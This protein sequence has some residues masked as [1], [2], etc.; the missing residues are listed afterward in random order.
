[1]CASAPAESSRSTAALPSSLP[2][3]STGASV[4]SQIALQSSS[5]P[6]SLGEAAKMTACGVAVE[7]LQR[8]FHAADDGGQRLLSLQCVRD[9]GSRSV[10]GVYHQ[11]SD[12]RLPLPLGYAD[13]TVRECLDR[14]CLPLPTVME[15]STTL[16][17]CSHI[18]AS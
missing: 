12:H 8:F 15:S 13:E 5:S 10:L 17:Y 3:T 11:Y 6:S 4:R 18:E 9:V 16:W 14:A 1:M 7:L 2:T